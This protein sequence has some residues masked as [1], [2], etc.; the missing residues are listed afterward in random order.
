MQTKKL[1]AGLSNSIN[2]INHRIII[3]SRKHDAA[4]FVASQC[5]AFQECLGN[6]FDM[7]AVFRHKHSCAVLKITIVLVCCVVIVL[8]QQTEQPTDILHIVVATFLPGR[9]WKKQSLGFTTSKRKDHVV[10]DTLRDIGVVKKSKLIALASKHCPDQ[11]RWSS[12]GDMTISASLYIP[13]NGRLIEFNTE[14]DQRDGMS[15][16]M[17]CNDLIDLC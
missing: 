5:L 7:V 2:K 12:A 15:A 11:P 1:I 13:N 17:V 3:D 14:P 6:K 16:F 10:L 9:A 8:M 4:Y